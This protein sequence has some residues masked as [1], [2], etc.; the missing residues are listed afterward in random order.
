MK[1]LGRVEKTE[2]GFEII[3]FRDI[4]GAPCT[5][6]M[7]SLAEHTMPGVSAVWLGP[8]DAAPKVIWHRAA[9]VGVKTDATEGWVPY[10]IPEAVSLSTRMHLDRKQVK[11][12]IT[13]LQRWLDTGSFKPRR[14]NS[15]K[16]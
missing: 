1:N 8:M 6:Q 9:S 15:S 5:L 10:P 3:E 2:R 11:A 4:Y 12:L 16:Q 7:S 14:R 13:T